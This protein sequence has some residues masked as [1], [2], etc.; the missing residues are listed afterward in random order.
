LPGAV[1]AKG[2]PSRTQ[3]RTEC[4]FRDNSS[5]P[6]GIDEL[7]LADDTIGIPDQI[8]EQVKDLGFNWDDL[9]CSSQFVACNVDFKVGKTEIQGVLAPFLRST[10]SPFTP[11]E[12]VGNVIDVTQVA[13]AESLHRYRPIKR[14]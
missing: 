3:P 12:L 14:T 8:N 6:H 5:K 2:A 1:V 13:A 9:V 11:S 10:G 7:I 4:G